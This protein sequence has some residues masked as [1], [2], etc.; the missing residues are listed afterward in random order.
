[1]DNFLSLFY[2]GERG[3][4]RKVIL[5]TQ[6]KYN[7]HNWFKFLYDDIYFK[8]NTTIDLLKESFHSELRL[9]I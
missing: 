4:I 7:S 5:C 6:S 8:M 9:Y 2:K 1:M 3:E